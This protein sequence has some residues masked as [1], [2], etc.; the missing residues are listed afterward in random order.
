MKVLSLFFT[1]FFCCHL[2]SG[3]IPSED[4][5]IRVIFCSDLHYG[6]KREFRGDTV[7][8]QQVIQAMLAT[9]KILPAQKLPDDG[10]VGSGK[11]FGKPDLIVCTG[12]ITNRMQDGVQTAAESWKQFCEDWKDIVDVPLC[13]VPG[14]HDLSNAIG[15]PK[16]LSPAKDASSAIGIYNRMMK[17]K[18]SRTAETFNYRNDPVHY[19]MII[20]S[21]RFAFISMWPDVRM[22]AW[23]D[24]EL[25]KTPLPTLIFTHDPP[26]A[27]TKHFTNPNGDHSINPHD[28]FENLLADTCKV[29]NI[30]QPAKA[31]WKILEEYVKRHPEI[32]AYFHGDK[33]YHEFYTWKG[34][35]VF[36][37]DSPMKGEYSAVD[38]RKLSFIVIMIDPDRK[39]LSARECLWN[40]ENRTS[41]VWGESTSISLH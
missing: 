4:R 19:S 21:I 25:K 18:I 13:L 28:R 22:R 39:I 3:H 30:H 26:S 15:Y 33:N 23:L 2:T 14:N 40:T 7:N 20:D 11:V 31:N 37:V 34:L 17:P 1:L 38:E 27:D 9:F 5:I 6:L 8:S 10:G 16:R 36:R 32:K 35:P 24:Q 41:V 29:S 12:D